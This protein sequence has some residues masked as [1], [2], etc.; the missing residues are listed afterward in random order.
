MLQRP[1]SSLSD[2]IQSTLPVPRTHRWLRWCA[3]GIVMTAVYSATYLTVRKAFRSPDGRMKVDTGSRMSNHI[4]APA[5]LLEK[6]SRDQPIPHP[7][8]L[9]ASC[10]A[11]S[12][13]SK[14]PILVALG[15]SGCLPCR[16][17]EKFLHDQ[18][19]IVSRHFVVVKADIDGEWSLGALISDRFRNPQ[20]TAGYVHS[21]PWIAFLNEHGELLVTVDDSPKRL[22]GTPQG[23]PEDRAWFLRML[24]TARPELTD[25]EIAT[26]DRAAEAYHNL[27]WRKID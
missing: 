26:L 1:Q 21:Y 8:S 19:A 13:A 27:V 25:S 10:L 23:G 5:I 16:Q 18:Q 24:R 3:A 9:W 15:I 6:K 4:F 14:K 20:G 7:E 11:E 22:I 2:S 12:S 17:L